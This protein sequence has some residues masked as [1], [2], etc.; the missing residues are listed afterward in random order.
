[1]INHHKY[2]DKEAFTLNGFDYTGFF[3]LSGKDAYSGR[4]I[5]PESKVLSNKNTFSNRCYI[6]GYELDN[7]DD[8]MKGVSEHFVKNF[9]VLNDERVNQ[10][11][12]GINTNNLNIFSNLVITSPTI[13]NTKYCNLKF[14]TVDYKDGVDVSVLSSYN[15]FRVSKPFKETDNFSFLDDVITSNFIVN[16]SNNSLYY[17]VNDDG[18]YVLKGNFEG[19]GNLSAINLIPFEPFYNNINE[20]IIKED[21]KKM[22]AIDNEYISIYDIS[23][24]GNCSEPI[25][26][27]R[28]KQKYTPIYHIHKWNELKLKW[29]EVFYK[30]TKRYSVINQNQPKFIK[31]GKKYRLQI[32]EPSSKQLELYVKYNE[33]VIQ[34]LDLSNIINGDILA[35][36]IRDTD[37]FIVVFWRT[38]DDDHMLSFFDHGDL[39]NTIKTTNIKDILTSNISDYTVGFVHSDSNLLSISNNSQYQYRYISNPTF[40]VGKVEKIDFNFIENLKWNTIFSTFGETP[41]PWNYLNS[42]VNG[43]DDFSINIT[44]K[45]NKMY[46]ILRTKGRIYTMFQPINIEKQFLID[47]NLSTEYNTFINNDS[48]IGMQ[49][50]NK[51]I[52]ILGD[53][54]SLAKSTISIPFYIESNLNR[55]TPETP[56]INKYNLKINTNEGFNVITIN[57]ILEDIYTIQRQL[58]VE[59]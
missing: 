2:T 28:I 29:N 27:D 52:S 22:V 45:N 37:D 57:R 5:T 34:T 51:T 30:Y 59:N 58:I 18:M 14:Y 33:S 50:N 7:S 24:F 39:E 1:M 26:I 40:P 44:Y 31:F 36:D 16:G 38:S 55:L 48:S 4:Y 15:D 42:G 23:T 49:F 20:L 53:I 19:M 3:T 56:T 10:L 47:K 13:F 54:L 46:G 25:L 12:D 9:D 41:V 6:N 17:I 8:N 11:F 35:I 21:D 43:I 32:S